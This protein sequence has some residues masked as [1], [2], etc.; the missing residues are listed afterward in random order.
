MPGSGP[1][2]LRA[3]PAP[4]RGAAVPPPP[5]PPRS[6]LAASR[7]F[8]S[9]PGLLRGD[10]GARPPPPRAQGSADRLWTLRLHSARGRFS[11]GAF[12]LGIS[13]C[14]PRN[15]L[16]SSLSDP[17][18][19]KQESGPS[20]PRSPRPSRHPWAVAPV[21]G[22]TAPRVCL[23]HP[24]PLTGCGLGNWSF[25][26]L[27]SVPYSGLRGG[28]THGSDVFGGTAGGSDVFGGTAGVKGHARDGGPCRL[29]RARS[30][31]GLGR[32]ASPVRGQTQKTGCAG[33]GFANFP[34]RGLLRSPHFPGSGCPGHERADG[35]RECPRSSPK[36]RAV[37]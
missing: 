9:G 17:M 8:G 7:L 23:L 3:P 33:T 35:D 37:S 36:K 11:S 29:R 13:S 25:L 4:S 32:G 14:S 30:P 26:S 27:S 24:E 20:A 31:R 6:L 10:A 16:G 1:Q 22:R 15:F 5:P 19:Q 18:F 12:R 2:T 28:D 34:E 21:A